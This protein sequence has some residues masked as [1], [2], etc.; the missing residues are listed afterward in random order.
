MAGSWGDFLDTITNA[1]E[2]MHIAFPTLFPCAT[3]QALLDTYLVI[4]NTTL[5]SEAA[6]IQACHD[7]L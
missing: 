4:K 7:S 5:M 3:A 1:M 2:V 6:A